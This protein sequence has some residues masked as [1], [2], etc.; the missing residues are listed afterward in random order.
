MKQVNIISNPAERRAVVLK[1]KPSITKDFATLR[2]V[3]QKDPSPVIRHEAAFK[4]GSSKSK[5]AVK[6]LIESIINDPSDLVR[7]ESLEALGDLGIK[8][9]EV[10]ELLSRYKK[11]K[12]EFI[13]DTAHMALLTISK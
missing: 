9:K 8:T 10:I 6:P 5:K 12:N 7:H 3:L 13:R 11:H 4:L 1:L 2:S